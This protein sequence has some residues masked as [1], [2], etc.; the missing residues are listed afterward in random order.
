MQQ[1]LTA[2]DSNLLDEIQND[3]P[4]TPRPFKEIG[5]LAGIGEE[6]CIRRLNALLEKGVLRE[7]SA[8][9]NAA[10]LGYK[11]TLVAAA[12]SPEHLE[13]AAL[14]IN[15]HPGVSHNYQRDHR[16]NLWFTLTIPDTRDFE[17]EIGRLDEGGR[18]LSCHILPSLKNFKLG[19]R[20]NVGK[21]KAHSSART[22]SAPPEGSR[23]SIRSL[24]EMIP[25][26]REL[27]K[28]FPLCRYPWKSIGEV[29][30]MEE[31]T[32]LEKIGELKRM[33]VIRRIAGVLRHRKAGFVANGMACFPIPETDIQ[34][35]GERAAR[36]PEVSH[37][38]QRPVFPDWPYSL[39]AM[40]HSKSDEECQAAIESIGEAI[41]CSNGI[42]LYSTREFKKERVKYFTE[43]T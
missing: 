21:R 38:Y 12:V 42:T 22:P 11:S 24:Q 7:I 3:L 9:Y 36:F 19:V 43:E 15:K 16:Y 32:V 25:L 30:S 28:P 35:A 14:R 20:F 23:S 5:R 8:I 33:K 4:L 40:V 17:Q 31:S 26:I 34:E 27:Q 2:E 10:H 18:F 29:L 37:C 1:E 13:E 6:N 39:F 41:G